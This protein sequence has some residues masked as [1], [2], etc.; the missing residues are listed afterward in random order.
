MWIKEINDYPFRYPY[1]Q[2]NSNPPDVDFESLLGIKFL[3][4]DVATTTLT[5]TGSSE[6]IEISL[7][8]FLSENNVIYLKC[9]KDS[10]FEKV[11][12]ETMFEISEMFP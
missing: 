4:F 6:S 3:S 11:Y 9:F 2:E 7:F 10:L 8:A 1:L 5:T 12:L